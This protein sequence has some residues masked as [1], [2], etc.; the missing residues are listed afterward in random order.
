MKNQSQAVP[1]A[2]ATQTSAT[3]LKFDLRLNQPDFWNKVS[4]SKEETLLARWTELGV[5]KQVAEARAGADKFWLLDGPPY[6]NGEAHLGHLLNKTLKDVNARFQSATGKD[7]VWRAGWDTHGLPLE[8]AVEKRRGPGA[9]D[10]PVAFMAECREEATTWQKVQADSMRRLGLMADL[11]TPWLS[12]EPAREAA[13]LGLLKEL[14]D[15]H[16][17]VE[18]HSPVHW[19][20]ACQSALAASE[21]EK[22]E[23]ARTEV[24]FTAQLTDES[25]AKLAAY[26]GQQLGQVHVLSWTTTPWTV[27]A[28]AAFAHP[29]RGMATLVTLADGKV[30]LMAA[31]ARNAFVNAHEHLV[32][33]P[34]YLRDNVVDFAELAGLQLQAVSSLSQRAVPLLPAS[35]ATANEGSGFVHV[36]PAFGP[37][38]FDLYEAHPGQVQLECHVGTNGRLLTTDP[39]QPLPASLEGLTLEAATLVSCELLRDAGQLVL[40]MEATVEAQACWRH[41][42]ATFYRASPQW[43]LDLHAPFDGCPEGLAARATAA[44]DATKFV[45]DERAK[46]PLATML[47]TRRFWTLSRDRLWGLPL[48][49]FRHEVTNE[50]HPDTATFW[51]ELVDLVRQD[52]VEAWHAME[53]PA[54][55]RKTMQ[56]VDVWFDSGAAWH[57]AAEQG[58][59]LP[60]LGVEGRDQTRGWFLSSFLLHAFKS[61]KPAFD[62]LM[63]H[64][65]VVGEDGL[66]L[67]KSK[68]GAGGTNAMAPAAV[69]AVEGADAFRLW[70]AAQNV[71][72]EA[73][74]GRTALKQASQDLKDWRS[75]L[76]FMLANMAE[77]PSSEAP[78]DLQSLDQ[79]ALHKA[80][81]AREE[82]SVHMAAGRFNQAMQVLTGF[83]LWA[84]ADW[85][86][87]NK[88]SLY[89]ARS[90]NPALRS[91]QWALQ[92][93][94][95]LFCHMLAPVVPF[96]AEEAYLA[97]PQHPDVSV[98]VGVVPGWQVPSTQAVRKV[99]ADLAWRRG[100]MPL[101]ERARGLV[102]KGVPVALAFGT[103]APAGFDEN[104][105]REWFPNTFPRLGGDTDEFVEYVRE[106]GTGVVA[107]RAAPAYAPARCDRCRGYFRTSSLSGALCSQ[108]TREMTQ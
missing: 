41:K 37:E 38:D 15:A 13:A 84:S 7:V 17:L 23:K 78:A 8:L 56:T 65:F 85:F 48:P 47:A 6:A 55:Y 59:S 108:C 102:E 94:F 36:A 46:T 4:P 72:D 66:K 97:W 87:L 35:F 3:A 61:D 100:L 93:V 32:Q 28:N 90:D 79:L 89:C 86:E 16:L 53:T 69:F 26:T 14:W 107:G 39:E 67:S 63:T 11:D 24:F 51:N 19:C 1:A 99:E 21:L 10:E 81:S 71:G 92:Q 88:R 45:P 103:D 49:F 52:G 98:F 30:V 76:R 31:E 101:V 42:K 58:C 18:R 60:S 91:T 12:M 80:A 34:G 74:W 29:E 50:L 44:L 64:S 9:K 62:T 96:S 75:F 105:L 54:G 5:V 57:T 43:A 20:P 104:L 33:D 22:T 77:E 2:L 83:R 40:Q 25:C 106:A 27:W 73:R 95:D 68:G 82:W 70:V